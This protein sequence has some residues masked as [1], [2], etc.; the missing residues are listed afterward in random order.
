MHYERHPE[1]M[2]TV[3]WLR[4]AGR[5]SAPRIPFQID[6]IPVGRICGRPPQIDS[7][8]C[9]PVGR[10]CG[11]LPEGRDGSKVQSSPLSEILTDVMHCK[12]NNNFSRFWKVRSRD[13]K[14]WAA[15][16]RSRPQPSTAAG[17]QPSAPPAAAR[18]RPQSSTTARSQ[19]SAAVQLCG[20]F[21]GVCL[22]LRAS[23]G[24]HA[25]GSLAPTG[26]P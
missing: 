8:N 15:A 7:N 16:V 23:S 12:K 25:Q 13:V 21:E 14:G 18:S 9:I 6:S 17:L 2:R 10:I 5:D 22:V 4:P 1:S 19:P 24:K 26:G 3:P 20:R 11:I